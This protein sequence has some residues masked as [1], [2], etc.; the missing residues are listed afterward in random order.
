MLAGAA[1]NR[2]GA[3]AAGMGIAAGDINGDLRPDLYVTNYFNETNTLFRNE[4]SLTFLDAGVELGLAAPSRLRLGFGVTLADFDNDGWSDYFV[5]NGHVQD[6]LDQAGIHD[7]PFAQFPQLLQNRGGRRF[8]DVSA[9]SG[10]FFRLPAVARGTA[11]ADVDGDG[12]ID[13]AVLRLNDRAAWLRNVTPAVGRWLSIELLGTSS[14]RDAIGATVMVHA[15]GQAWRRDRMASAS[16]LSCDAPELHFG[17]GDVDA[18]SRVTVRWP[19]GRREGFANVPIGARTRLVE[20]QG[21]P[22]E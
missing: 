5:A 16:Y 11:A 19:S 22:E 21:A 7:Q 14:N 4:G 18:V 13:L 20:G 12:R 2:T 17:L 1:V 3:A 8:E 9:D 6:Q 15:P 10:P